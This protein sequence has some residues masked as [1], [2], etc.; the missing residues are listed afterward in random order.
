MH[1]RLQKAR[2]VD[3]NSYGTEKNV[4]KAGDRRDKKRVCRIQ[5]RNSV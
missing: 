4:N 2:E 3:L 1:P 5:R